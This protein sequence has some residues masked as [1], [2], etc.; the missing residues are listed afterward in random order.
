MYV[1]AMHPRLHHQVW[2][3]GT[4]AVKYGAITTPV[5]PEDS[6]DP[7]FTWG[8]VLTRL[9]IPALELWVH[10]DPDV[11]TDGLPSVITSW[12]A[13]PSMQIAQ[14]STGAAGLTSDQSRYY[15]KYVTWWDTAREVDVTVITGT[16]GDLFIMGGNGRTLDRVA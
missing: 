2:D 7:E 1:K 11:Y 16:E 4:S 12:T 8:K 13:S 5:A 6:S 3:A 14:P 15:F 9:A 10:G